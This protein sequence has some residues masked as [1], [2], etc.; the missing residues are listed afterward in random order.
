MVRCPNDGTLLFNPYQGCPICGWAVKPHSL[1]K[2]NPKPSDFPSGKRKFAGY[3]PV[4]D[5]TIVR[6]EPFERCNRCGTRVHF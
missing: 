5:I 1:L 4:C 3:C 2:H 6:A